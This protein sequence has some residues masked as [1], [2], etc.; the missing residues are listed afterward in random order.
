M[1]ASPPPSDRGD[2]EHSV[3]HED[4]QD[5]VSPLNGGPSPSGEKRN[6]D[7]N[8]QD[9]V[10]DDARKKRKK[11]SGWDDGMATTKPSAAASA[12]V[13]PQP[14]TSAQ[15]QSLALPA[16]QSINPA[17]VSLGLSLEQRAKLEQ[18]KA[19]A[20]EITAKLLRSKLGQAPLIAPMGIA[21]NAGVEARS[22]A[23]M[24]RI[25]V[26][27]INF[28]LNEVHIK[29]VF[30][31]FGYVKSVSMTMDPTTGKHKGFCFVEYEVPEAAELALEVMNG[32]DL[33]GRQLKVGRPNNYNPGIGANLPPP[34]PSRIYIAN[35]SEFVSEQN[36]ESIFESFGKI[37]GCSLLP[38]LQLRKHK[39]CGYLEFEEE[40]SAASAITSMNNF[41][42]GCLPLRVR[43]A[44]I[45]GPMP[46]GMKN[47]D[48]LPVIPVVPAVVPARVLNVAQNINS[49]I[50]Q[51]TGLAPAPSFQ[52][53]S[54]NPALQ[55]A[56]AKVKAQ[57]MNDDNSTLEE[58]VSISAN[59]RF[60]IM[61]KLMRSKTETAPRTNI[62][63][64]RD[65]VFFKDLDDTLNEEITEECGKYGQVTKVLIWV[66]PVK[67]ANGTLQDEDAVDIFV[68]F[69]S[70]D[71]AA[72]ARQ[73]LDK[74][75][76]AG[77][78]ISAAF[79]TPEEFARKEAQSR[80]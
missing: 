20:R 41:E 65:M 64:L 5:T 78:Q 31:Q 60:A 48:Q 56:I 24:S 28:E 70:A 71:W 54:V 27:S 22:I 40:T 15:T 3:K 35:I 36:V 58:N 33:G 49:T 26:G 39:G 38:D 34:I 32:A 50:A 10:E 12:S 68:E 61:Q 53:P 16:V 59:Q 52:M 1:M 74:R 73:G 69:G 45:G 72:Q 62:V 17:P 75:W 23:V 25:Y 80:G 43:P 11:P 14:E 46:V 66:D 9:D 51:R 4:E 44:I 30:S 6:R 29:A 55:N 67:Q 7:E 19:Y 42:L 18:A 8:N 2:A 37:K 47:L 76:F 63:S 21:L 57:I 79:I 77:R 13:S